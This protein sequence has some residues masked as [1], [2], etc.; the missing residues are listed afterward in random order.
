MLDLI[1]WLIKLPFVMLGWIVMAAFWFIG[2]ILL[3]VGAVLTPVLG[4]GLLILPFGFLFLL[5]A[6]LIRKL[7]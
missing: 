2:V 7:L 1:V 3:V 5:V 6:K 4:I